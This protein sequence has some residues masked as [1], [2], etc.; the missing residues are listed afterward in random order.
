MHVVEVVAGFIDSAE[1]KLLSGKGPSNADFLDRLYR[2][3]FYHS[4]DQADTAWWI[5]E[6]A[7]TPAKTWHKVLADFSESSEKQMNVPSL[8]ANSISY[9]SRPR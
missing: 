4:L 3:I 2:N 6:M 7:N 1:F 8:I 9:D 5:N